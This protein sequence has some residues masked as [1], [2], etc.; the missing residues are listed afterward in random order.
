MDGLKTINDHFGHQQGD[1][2][3][4]QIGSTM[5]SLSRTSDIAARLGGDEFVLLAPQTDTDGACEIAERLRR[6]VESC[7]IGIDDPDAR[8]SA[9]V[10]VASYPTHAFDAEELLAKADA[11]MYEAK[12]AGKNRVCVAPEPPEPDTAE[13]TD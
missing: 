7:Q 2:A 1:V 5:R 11:A 13:P 10:G 3:L 12:K 8:F 4:K 9:S 6:E